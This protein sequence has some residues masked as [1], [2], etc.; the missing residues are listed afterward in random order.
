MGDGVDEAV[1]L[2]VPLDLEDEEHGVDDE[3][4]DDQAEEDDAEDDGRD[5]AGIGDDPA[6]VQ[7]DRRRDE[8]HAQRDEERDRL[9][10]SGH[11]SDR[12]LQQKRGEEQS[13][14]ASTLRCK[15]R[16]LP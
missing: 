3:A 6:D 7:R 9:L 13:D 1:V 5:A 12:L 2:L 14:L 11:R 10:P 8:Q 16:A 15:L 4:G